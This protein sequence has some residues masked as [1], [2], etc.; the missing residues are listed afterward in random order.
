MSAL[1]VDRIPRRPACCAPQKG[2]VRPRSRLAHPRGDQLRRK[3]QQFVRRQAPRMGARRGERALE[4]PPETPERG[5]RP[6]SREARQTHRDEDAVIRARER[7][8]PRMQCPPTGVAKQF[9]A[10]PGHDGQNAP[11]PPPRSGPGRQRGAEPGARPVNDLDRRTI[12]CGIG[13][14][15]RERAERFGIDPGERRYLQ[16]EPVALG[17][18]VEFRLLVPG[19]PG[20]EVVQRLR[21]RWRHPRRHRVWALEEIHEARDHGVFLQPAGSITTRTQLASW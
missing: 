3:R 19:P 21:A 4:R 18:D 9:L 11:V 13:Q 14:D 15:A 17:I 2:F 6:R 8:T 5:F 12:R 7:R 20:Q 16:H 10:P 1:H